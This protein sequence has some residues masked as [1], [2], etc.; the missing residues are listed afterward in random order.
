MREVTGGGEI[1][2]YAAMTENTTLSGL[3]DAV[4]DPPPTLSRDLLADDA[5]VHETRVR[6]VTGRTHQ[7][8]AQLAALGA[9]LLGDTLYASGS[10]LLDANDDEQ[11][12][13]AARRSAVASRAC[14]RA[15]MHSARSRSIL[16][17][18]CSGSILRKCHSA[19]AFLTVS[20]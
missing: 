5:R 16:D 15:C 10:C 20:M 7:I 17:L 14:C 1:A 12:V 13:A 9:P 2:L 19:I 3:C 8:R 6:L 11:R 4:A 18:V